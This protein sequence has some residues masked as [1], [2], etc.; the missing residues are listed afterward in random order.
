[1]TIKN[2][3]RKKAHTMEDFEYL[4]HHIEVDDDGNEEIHHCFVYD[5]IAN[6]FVHGHLVVRD[7]KIFIDGKKAKDGV[8]HVI[9]GLE[10]TQDV[11]WSDKQAEENDIRPKK[12]KAGMKFKQKSKEW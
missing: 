3:F 2:L 7:G 10:L 4:L 6:L 8:Y 5:H 11:S 12:M 9:T 1:M